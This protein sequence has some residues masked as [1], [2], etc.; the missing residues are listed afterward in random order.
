MS[1]SHAAASQLLQRRDAIVQL[2]DS[3]HRSRWTSGTT[4]QLGV[5]GCMRPA[6]RDGVGCHHRRELPAQL[7]DLL[8]TGELLRLG[9]VTEIVER[10]EL[11][12]RAHEIA[13]AIARKPSAATQGTVRAI[14]ESLDRPYRAAMQQG[15]IY[16]RV[17]NPI[18]Q[19]EIADKG[20]DKPEPRFR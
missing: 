7:R 8:I 15:L 5:D 18:G 1:G 3:G 13:A 4:T 17:G 16:T 12:P 14:W 20:P 10:D 6:R 2:L 9:L 11:W 19:Q